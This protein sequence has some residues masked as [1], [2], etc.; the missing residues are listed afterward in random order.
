MNYFDT[1]EKKR[2]HV[3]K[4]DMTKIPSKEKIDRAL[5]KAWKTSPSK[6]Q[7]MAYQCLVWGPDKEIHKEAIHNLVS[8]SLIV[9]QN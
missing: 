1:L 3:K 8:K 9:N 5:Y 6:N 2:N 7:S 4:Y